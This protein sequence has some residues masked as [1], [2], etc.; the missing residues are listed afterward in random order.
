M[1]CGRP[2]G[3]GQ[4][5]PGRRGSQGAPARGVQ[6]ARMGHGADAADLAHVHVCAAHAVNSY[7]GMT[8]LGVMPSL[9]L[10]VRY[11]RCGVVCPSG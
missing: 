3:A 11:W 1:P 9:A 5:V 10:V 4:G 6:A 8:E 2:L 7:A